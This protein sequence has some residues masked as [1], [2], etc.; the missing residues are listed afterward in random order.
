MRTVLDLLTEPEE[1]QKF[2]ELCKSFDSIYELKKCLDK[3]QVWFST[4]E[5]Q[6]LN[7]EEFCT[8]F[9]KNCTDEPILYVT[10]HY[11]YLAEPVNKIVLQSSRLVFRY[12]C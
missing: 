8:I 11:P 1:F 9:D 6:L 2:P 10:V 4:G 7:V 12:Y 3:H 5:G